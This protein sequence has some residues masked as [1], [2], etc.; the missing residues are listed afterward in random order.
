MRIVA[1]IQVFNERRFIA[2]CVEHLREQGI[3]VYLIDNESTDDTVAIAERYLGNGVIGIE[4][5]PRPGGFELRR[6]CR[7]QEELAAELDADWLIHHDADEMRAS[8]QRGQSLAEAIRE[9]DEAGFNAVNFLEFAFVPTLEA[10]DH[11]HPAFAL[12]MRSYYPFQPWF[13]HRCNAWKRQDE[14][15]ELEWSAGHV[16]RFPDL[17]MAPRTL[18]MRHYLFLN[19]EHAQHKFV[20]RAFSEDEV[21]DGWYGW[22]ATLKAED[23][24]LPSAGRL[25]SYLAD[26]LL[27]G[28]N[29]WQHHVLDPEWQLSEAAAS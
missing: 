20:R 18:A 17:R 27:D 23:V 24:R 10:P 5:L 3:D 9:A 8:T 21:D 25:R 12:T 15:V 4:S 6:Q 11:D 14:P 13:P 29:P 26:H 1:M 28:T 2:P 16:V 19:V 7:R 22:R